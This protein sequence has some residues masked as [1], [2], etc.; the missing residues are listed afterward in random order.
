MQ[1]AAGPL[2]VAEAVSFARAHGIRIEDDVR[3]VVAD[4]LLREG[5]DAA[6]GAFKSTSSYQWNDLLV[7]GTIVVKVRGTVLQ[8]EEAILCVFA[9]EMHEVSTARDQRA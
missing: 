6:Y 3:F 9:H 8:S 7:Q 1:R 5:E 4:S 2:T